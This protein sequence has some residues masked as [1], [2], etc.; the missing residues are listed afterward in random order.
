MKINISLG[1][2]QNLFQVITQDQNKLRQDQWQLVKLK[3]NLQAEISV[4]KKDCALLK[5]T[6]R[7]S[8]ADQL[9]SSQL[10]TTEEELK[11][12]NQMMKKIDQALI[13]IKN[14]LHGIE[15]YFKSQRKIDISNL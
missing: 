8:G 5:K 9:L 15:D 4:L 2:F 6:I 3:H 12:S 13:A 1:L 11:I 7:E 10:K 14:S